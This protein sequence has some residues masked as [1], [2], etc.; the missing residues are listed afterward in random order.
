MA[1]HSPE[2]PKWVTMNAVN[3]AVLATIARFVP[4]EV[5]VK[6]RSGLSSNFNMEQAAELPSSARCFIFIRFTE[7]IPISEPEKNASN[8]IPS[9]TSI[10]VVAKS[11]SLLD[12]HAAHYL[13]AMSEVT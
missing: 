1:I 6:S 7:T 13:A 11:I 5:V 4:S 10:N 12:P 8:S 3:T 2:S 9:I